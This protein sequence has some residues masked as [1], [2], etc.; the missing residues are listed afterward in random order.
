MGRLSAG[1]NARSDPRDVASYER[2]RPK[3]T[4]LYGIVE[5]YCPVFLKLLFYQGGSL[6]GYGQREFG[7]YLK[8][9]R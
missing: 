1:T 6:P 4:L 7:D 2:H 9:G 5:E 3:Q 8:R